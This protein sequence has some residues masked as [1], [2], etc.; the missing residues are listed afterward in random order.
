MNK[1]IEQVIQQE[2]SKHP[3]EDRQIIATMMQDKLLGITTSKNDYKN[4][5]S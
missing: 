2:L 3:V 4:M 1:D 5:R